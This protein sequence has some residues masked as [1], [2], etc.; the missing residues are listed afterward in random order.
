MNATRTRPAWTRWIGFGAIA[1]V[2]AVTLAP[3]GPGIARAFADFEFRAPDFS[4]WAQVSWVVKLHVYAAL[5]AL[6]IGTVILFRRKGSGFHKT[7][8]WAWVL[9]MG[10]TAI[11]SLFIMEVNR[12]FFSFIHLLS[13]WTIIALPMAIFAIRN[14]KVDAHRR[15]MTG[16][17]V[18]GLL[19]AGL[20]SFIPGR[21]MFEMFFG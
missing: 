16:M 15:A 3:F 11:S 13:G 21:V 8:G 17:F 19:V 20:L 9:A 6:A 14:R 5:T 4:L 18:G 2:F 12:G 7:L 1:A 10:T